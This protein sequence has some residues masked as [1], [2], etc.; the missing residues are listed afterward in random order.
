MDAETVSSSPARAPRSRKDRPCDYCR[1]LKHRC[2]IIRRGEQCTN[3]LRTKRECTFITS[4]RSVRR[5]LTSPISI[6][7]RGED[8]EPVAVL[9]YVLPAVTGP[10]VLEL[11]MNRESNHEVSLC[12]DQPWRTLLILQGS[13]YYPSLDME[14]EDSQESQYLGSAAFSNL[15]PS[16]Q[17]SSPLLTTSAAVSG[18]IAYRQVSD[19]SQPVFFLRTSSKVYGLAN[20]AYA[21]DKAWQAVIATLKASKEDSPARL[22]QL[23]IDRTLPALPLINRSRLEAA[24][25]GNH[26]AGPFPSAVMVGVLTHALVLVPAMRHLAKQLWGIALSLLDNE[27]RQPR[28]STLQLALLDIYGWPILNPGGN[29]MAISRASLYH[30]LNLTLSRQWVRRNSWGCIVT[31]HIG[32]CRA[33]KRRHANASGGLFI[34]PTNGMCFAVENVLLLDSS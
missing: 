6:S 23:F 15:S 7:V 24:C 16:D 2:V 9:D 27:Y 20:G 32:S 22:F 5:R 26:S 4:A 8:V 1:R 25:A 17:A 10:A 28:L 33:G 31:V 18:G 21:A 11:H 34:L 30:R 3:C 13:T 29:H 19:P 12:P 14:L